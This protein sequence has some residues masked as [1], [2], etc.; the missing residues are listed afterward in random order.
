MEKQEKIEDFPFLMKL[1]TYKV[2]QKGCVLIGILYR[3]DAQERKINFIEQLKKRDLISR[4]AW[5]FKYKT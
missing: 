3:T 4:Y 5:T 2:A 1:S